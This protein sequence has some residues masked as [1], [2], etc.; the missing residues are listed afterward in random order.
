MT[1][2]PPLSA[3]GPTSSST[4][5]ETTPLLSKKHSTHFADRHSLSEVGEGDESDNEGGKGTGREVDVYV[6]GKSS[7][8]QTL[9]NTLGDI[10]GTGLLA[11]PIAIA[12]AGWIFGP[13]FLIIIGAVTLYTLK[14][15]LRI[16]EQD[17]RLRSFTDVIGY[18]LGPRGEKWVTTLFIIEVCAWVVA[19]VVLFSDSLEAVWPVFTSDQWKM[20]G[21]VVIIPTG[22]VPL[23]YLSFSS[24][25]GIT[26]TWTLVGI[27]IFSGIATPHA[28]GSLRDPEH[29][30]LLPSHGLVKLG[31]VFGLLISGFGGH[32]L[33]PNLIRDM[34]H[35]K[36]ADRVCEVAYGIA[37]SVYLL[38][39]VVGYLMYGTDVSDEISKDLAKTPGFSPLLNKLAVWMVAINPLTK[40]PLGLRPLA[41]II[42]SY[43]NLHPTLLVPS[44]AP[45]PRYL[46]RP[47]SPSSSSSSTS[48]LS[49]HLEPP[50]T[51][52]PTSIETAHNRRERIKSIIRPIIRVLLA[53]LAIVGALVMPSFES[54]LSLLGS[55]FAVASTI[56]IPVW[57]GASVFGWKWYQI[58]ICVIST[59]VAILGII[60]AFWPEAHHGFL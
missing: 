49:S 48:S 24:A 28:P 23:R 59:I 52:M 27:L 60:S 36:Q 18:G 43:F 9:L 25:L 40:I 12:H 53:V 54:V 3:S 33:I 2:T 34:K 35:P 58:V 46:T 50:P 22:F 6:P 32:G 17:R 42:F 38:V 8:S 26:G 45:T 51:H 39:A 21:L 14:I 55:G 44:T 1:S 57:A 13:L 47:N 11:C 7:F 10:I 5:T 19:L 15:L 20:V 41:D 56:L 29:T 16:I 37:M 31:T 4:L 30:D